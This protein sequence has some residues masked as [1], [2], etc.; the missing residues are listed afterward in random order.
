MCNY[1]IRLRDILTSFRFFDSV[2]A[3]ASSL[4]SRFHLLDLYFSSFYDSRI[5]S[6][7]NF[8]SMENPTSISI[9]TVSLS[10]L[11]ILVH[12]KLKEDNFITWKNLMSR[13]IRKFKI[14]RFLDSTHPCP[15]QFTN[16]KNQVNNIENHLYTDWMDEDAS[17]MMWIHSTISDAVIAYFSNCSTSHQLWTTSLQGLQDLQLLIQFSCVLNS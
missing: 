16:A 2:S 17:I 5:P 9:T 13:V 4:I 8:V 7:S 11:T 1:G 3:S 14:Q 6:S 15:P 10:Q 12:L